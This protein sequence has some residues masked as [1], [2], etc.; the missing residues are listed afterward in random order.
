MK[1]YRNN[2]V[3]GAILD[4]YEKAL[5]ELEHIIINLT[6]EDLVTVV[7]RKTEDPD[8]KSIQTILT[9]IINSGYVYVIEIRKSFGEKIDFVKHK[10]YDTPEHYI[11]ELK[12]MFQYNEQLFN[13]YP[14]SNIEV[15]DPEKKIVVS[16]GQRYDI[17]QLLEHAIVH[18]LRHRRQIERFIIELI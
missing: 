5:T 12:K 10:T 4:E 3:I 2:G 18:I 14:N 11:F 7:D 15:Y 1:K 16:W 9:H 13:D 6:I 17:E 8:C